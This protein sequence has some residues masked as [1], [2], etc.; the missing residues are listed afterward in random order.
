MKTFLITAAAV[1]TL[2][3]AAYAESHAMELSGDAAAGEAAFSQCQTCHVVES[4]EGETLAGRNART[5]PN[6]YG[7][8]GRQA[9]TV[10]GF[11]YGKDI[12]TAGEDGLVWDEESLSAYLQDPTGYLREVLDNKR[13]R[14]KMAYRVRSEED[15]LNLI[16]YLHSLAPDANM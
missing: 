8:V 10:E 1:G 6:L 5:G 13:A 4:P 11:R 16:A 7:V 3:T 9:G 15:A 2:S 14:G 12:V